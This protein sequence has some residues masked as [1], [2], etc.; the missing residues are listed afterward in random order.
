MCVDLATR[1][2]APIGRA[3][4]ENSPKTSA[5]ERQSCSAKGTANTGSSG[6]TIA[7]PA[8]ILYSSLYEYLI[9]QTKTTIFIRCPFAASSSLS[10]AREFRVVPK[11]ASVL[12]ETMTPS[13]SRY[14][15][16]HSVSSLSAPLSRR[17]L[18]VRG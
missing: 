6:R 16:C 12:I 13:P 7:E 10:L 17:S 3:C 8:A 1:E 5:C 14:C 15:Q 11:L 9:I 18:S 4:D 2:F